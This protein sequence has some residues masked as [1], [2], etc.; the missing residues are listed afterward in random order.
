MSVE[1]LI[2]DR[3]FKEALG[4]FVI[5]FS[6]LESG[7]VFLCLLTEDDLKN[8]DKQLVKY[9]G[10]P[11]HKKVEVISE[12]IK[13]SLKELEPVWSELKVEIGQLNRE[14]RFLV[15]GFT[16]YYLP[17]ETIK[18]Y[19]PEKGKV[20]AKSY[21]LEELKKLTDRIHHLNTD[22]ENGLKGDFNTLFTKLRVNK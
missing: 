7:L 19:V 15:H 12:Y 3:K 21:T 10:L 16:T 1:R 9:L 13:E 4:A 14:R 2:Q 17:K 11:F 6:E 22:K 5:A 18:T 20:V 8:K